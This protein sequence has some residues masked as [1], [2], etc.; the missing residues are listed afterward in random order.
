MIRRNSF[1]L[2]LGLLLLSACHKKGPTAAPESNHAPTVELVQ[3]TIRDL[4]RIVGQPSFIDSYEQTAIYAKLPGFILKWNVDIGDRVKKGDLLATLFI[5]ELEQEYKL[6]Q[7]NTQMDRAL[8]DQAKT[9]VEVAEGNLKAATAKV[10]EAKA[11]VAKFDALVRRWDSE[12]NRQI[13]MVNDRVIDQQILGESRRQFEASQASRE[14]SVAAVATAEAME[15]ARR[16]DLDKAKVDVEVAQAQLAVAEADEKRVD[17]LYSYTRLTAPYDAIVVWRNANTGD[18]VLPATGDPSAEPRSADQSTSKASPIYVVA[19]T[20]VVRIYVDVPE[21]EA[22]YIVSLVD[23][24][25]G[26][27]RPATPATVRVPAFHNDDVPA[28]VTRSSWA[29]NMKSRTLRAEIDISNPDAKLLPGMYAYGT[30][31]IEQPKARVLPEGTL[32]QS[33][34]DTVCFLYENGKAVKTQVQTGLRSDG[35]V[36]ILKKKVGGAWTDFTGQEQVIQADLTEIADGEEVT[37][38]RSAASG[39]SK[40]PGNP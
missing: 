15:L 10:A 28:K 37:A 21:Y 8:V 20:D 7:A 6:K 24:K 38:E 17:A 34:N 29:L 27:T 22:N 16:A 39:A 13:T 1:V 11:D 33:G 31:R 40:A 12:V 9:L 25:S 32:T 18:F 30:V 19:R 26:D 5:P 2:L 3:P 4:V 23:H 36:E 35:V 14:A